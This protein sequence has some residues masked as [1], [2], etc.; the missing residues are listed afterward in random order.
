MRS[1]FHRTILTICAILAVAGL[2][3]P[4]VL[5]LFGNE[6]HLLAA[7]KDDGFYLLTI[8]RSIGEGRG[9]TFDGIAPTNGFHPLWTLLLTPVFWL[10]KGSPFA[11]IRITILLAT[12]L[13]IGAALAIYRV[14]CYA[15]DRVAARLAAL[16]YLGNP[17][18]IYL[19]VSGMESALVAFLVAL[20]AGEMA[21]LCWGSTRI[22]EGRRILRVGILG[23][24]CMLARTDLVLLVGIV[25]LGLVLLR[26]EEGW[27][28]FRTRVRGA[29]FAGVIASVLILPWLLWNL[30]RFGTIVQVSAQAHRLH[31]VSQRL[32]GGEADAASFW[33]LG[34]SLVLSMF[35]R[36]GPRTGVPIPVLVV[37][38]ILVLLVLVLWFASLLARPE[39]R[40]DFRNRFC[41]VLAPTVYA[42][43][44]LFAT[45]FVLGHIRSWYVAGPLTVAGILVAFPAFYAF[46]HN[47]FARV[48]RFLSG[49]I[50]F[51][52]ILGMAPLWWVFGS[53]VVYNAR[54]ISPWKEA[55]EWVEART[56]PEDRVA[57]FRSGTFGFLASRTIVNLDCV[58]N[59]RAIPWLKRGEL[60]E[61]LRRDQIRYLIDDPGYAGT[62]LGLYAEK[63]WTD[64]VVPLEDLES[65]L[66]VY[67]VRPASA[68]SHNRNH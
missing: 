64:D 53:E 66:R 58:V 9:P 25:L 61:Y 32:A 17:L 44:F 55:S 10:T 36:I 27:I 12:L 60:I 31:S 30:F 65:G 67:R 33:N 62:Y 22:D 46:G 50:L 42:G 28:R 56:N 68:T 14:A 51:A 5:A 45:F 20:L 1:A 13:H 37:V 43:G 39:I 47:P 23:G 57:S 49:V 7:L 24:L 52:V 54:E 35:D 26:P 18:A 16:F 3:A 8:A 59:N 41:R 21:L 4:V 11:A 29:F 6:G 40:Q 15:T 48:G 2:V 38:V 19:V 34:P 63:D